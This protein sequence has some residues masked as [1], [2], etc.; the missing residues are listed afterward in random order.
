[1]DRCGGQF[2]YV[3]SLSDEKEVIMSAQESYSPSRSVR[4]AG[5]GM[6]GLLMLG[7]AG[8]SAPAMAASDS[9]NAAGDATVSAAVSGKQ[10]RNSKVR[11]HASNTQPNKGQTLRLKGKVTR[12]HHHHVR[13]LIQK[14]RPNGG[15]K[16]ISKTFT[17]R[18]GHFHVKE[19]FRHGDFNVRAKSQGGHLSRQVEIAVQ[20]NKPDPNQVQ[21]PAGDT[22][23][24]LKAINTAPNGATLNL[25]GT[26]NVSRTDDS[27]GWEAGTIINKD[28]TLSGGTIQSNGSDNVISV[29]RGSTLTLDGGINI[30]GGNADKGAGIYNEGRLIIKNAQ[31][32]A[33]TATSGG[34][35]AGIYNAA[36]GVVKMYDGTVNNNDNAAQGGGLY[37]DGGY[38]QIDGGWFKQNNAETGG[39]L[40]TTGKT[41]KVYVNGGGF[42][43]NTSQGGN[44]GNSITND[45][46]SGTVVIFGNT[47]QGND[48]NGDIG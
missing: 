46:T 28:L 35:G 15:W 31:V 17:N 45:Q 21:V 8:A 2:I 3:G 29:H 47:F 44:Q 24:L 9:A 41:A 42:W 12:A 36:T 34:Q 30:T 38:V 22:Q 40:Y 27:Q 6:A 39:G 7:I 11:L 10:F 13:V 33:N 4:L 1:M 25:S 18:N 14:E 19:S 5:A 16:R 20:S 23:A 26:Y 37:N 43:A 32:D 48:Y